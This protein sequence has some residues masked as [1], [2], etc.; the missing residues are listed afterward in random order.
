[1][2]NDFLQSQNLSTKY[3]LLQ[4]KNVPGGKYGRY[5]PVLVKNKFCQSWSWSSSLVHL[6]TLHQALVW[7]L[8]TGGKKTKVSQ[9]YDT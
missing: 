2:R 3:L 7:N 5:H 9:K 1:M 4:R 8:T 6:P